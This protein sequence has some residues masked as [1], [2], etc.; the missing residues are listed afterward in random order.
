M[1]PEK[2]KVI[3][4]GHS[5][6]SRHENNHLMT[7]KGSTKR[8]GKWFAICIHT[9]IYISHYIAIV[10]STRKSLP[11]LDLIIFGS[12]TWC[13]ALF[14]EGLRVH[15]HNI[16]IVGN[17]GRATSHHIQWHKP[18]LSL[19]DS[20]MKPLINLSFRECHVPKKSWKKHEGRL[21]CCS[22]AERCRAC[23]WW[24]FAQ[25]IVRDVWFT[26]PDWH[27]FSWSRGQQDAQLLEG[28]TQQCQPQIST[29]IKPID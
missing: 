8:S 17:S 27:R 2:K 16:R 6:S 28:L 14:V 19:F 29:V 24:N 7:Q 4:D 22:R 3:R 23:R 11:H 18:M 10:G 5:F 15:I 26:L 25:R 9:Y 21:L 12:L 1:E 20:P 13:L